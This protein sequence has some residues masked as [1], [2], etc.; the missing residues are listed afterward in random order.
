MD[1]KNKGS[2]DRCPLRANG[3]LSWL[4]NRLAICSLLFLL[5]GCMSS[6]EEIP[7]ALPNQMREFPVS[8]GDLSPCVFRAIEAIDS[9]YTFR[10]SASPNQ[11]EFFITAPRIS[12]T[13]TLRQLPEIEIHF[14]MVHDLFTTVEIK[15]DTKKSSWIG[16]TAW[17][18]IERCSQQ[19]SAP[20]AGIDAATP[21]A[22]PSSSNPIAP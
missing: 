21:P 6:T 19:V 1:D 17:P 3:R 14:F 16:V 8:A 10:L 7:Q 9:P 13:I 18:L 15:Q 11:R 22:V 2:N 4:M 20:A 12:D 5:S